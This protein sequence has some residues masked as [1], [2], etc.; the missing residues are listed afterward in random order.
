MNE[1]IDRSDSSKRSTAFSR[2]MQDLA[3]LEAQAEST[4]LRDNDMLS[5]I[6]SGTLNGEDIARRYPA[7]Y[8]K[9]LE[10]AELRDAFVEALEAFEA[11]R[12]GQLTPL[13]EASKTSL[14]FL[15]EPPAVPLLESVSPD[16]WRA[17]WQK[18]LEQI[19]AIFSPPQLAYR[20][21]ISEIEDP[22]FTL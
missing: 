12:A 15:N 20:A 5:Q 3:T 11:E 7:F 19:R 10:N 17:T 14:S 22:W 9:L 2:L 13:P 1:D 18:S 6:L 21:D 16:H 4:L 8:Q